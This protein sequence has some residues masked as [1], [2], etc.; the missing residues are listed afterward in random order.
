MIYIYHRLFC[1]CKTG[2]PFFVICCKCLIISGLFF[3][4]PGFSSGFVRFWILSFQLERTK[5][6]PEFFGILVR[7]AA[8]EGELRNGLVAYKLLAHRKAVAD[9]GKPAAELE[10]HLEQATR[11][12]VL[13]G[14]VFQGSLDAVEIGTKLSEFLFVGRE[15][16]LLQPFKLQVFQVVDLVLVFTVPLPECGLGNVDLA[17]DAGKAPAVGA[18]GD[19]GGKFG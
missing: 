15:I 9:F 6:L 5:R 19:E 1:E 13:K 3:D 16:F 7:D 11:L 8:S 12:H 10:G 14:A 17:S 18:E 4:P 2:R